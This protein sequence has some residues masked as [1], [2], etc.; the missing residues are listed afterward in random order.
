MLE[1]IRHIVAAEGEHRHRIVTYYAHC[2][3]RRRG[4]L[5]RHYRADEYAVFPVARFIDQ[6]SRFR[7]SAAE[8]HSGDR[9]ALRIFEFGGEAGAVLRR[10]G[11]TGVRMSA[12]D[13]FA[14]RV[15]HAARPLVAFPV[16]D[17]LRRILVESFPPY[18]LGAGIVNDV[19][20]Y[21]SALRGFES[22]GIGFRV[23]SG[24]YA[25]E[26]VFGVDGIEHTAATFTDPRDIVA[27]G[28]DFISF[29]G[30][31]FRRN[32]HCEV[33]LAASGG[34]RRRDVFDLAV[35]LLY[36]ED[37]HVLRHPAFF[38]A[39]IGSDTE[40][41]ALFAEK[42]VA[43]VTGVKAV[44]GVV[45]GELADITVLFFEFDLAVDA[46]H[47]IVGIAELVENFLRHAGHDRHVQYDVDGVGE[48]DAVFGEG[49][50]DLAHTEGDYIHRSAFHATVRYSVEF[51]VSFFGVHPVVGGTGV[52]LLAGADERPAFHARHVVD[53]GA[54]I[55][56]SGK[57]LAVAFIDLAGGAGNLGELVELFLAAVDPYYLVGLHKVD[58]LL[59]EIE[60][61][62]I[63][64]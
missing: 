19:G 24:S 30:V 13:G 1:V 41:E 9:H 4:G 11:E 25:E 54:V 60:N 53:G 29:R 36:A 12:L 35:G 21:R 32:E 48:L 57:Q 50:S 16:E 49:R 47:E 58:V 63:G 3:R 10:S 38:P 43:A 62:F 56:A 52:L 15:Y 64:R 44:N 28:E 17:V 18:R 55:E 23:R 8:Y 7:A 33:G 51:S 45:L 37:E 59:D 26:A 61:V 40:R 2:A 5:R 39:L 6:R 46:A 27:H 14:V 31:G 22:V 42:H 20:E 34:E